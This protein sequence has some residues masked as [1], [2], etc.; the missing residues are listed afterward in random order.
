[1][2]EATHEVTICAQ[3]D[4]IWE[5]VKEMNNWAPLVTGYQRHEII[6]ERHSLWVL[7]GDVGALSRTVELDIHILEW[8]GPERVHFS[9]KGR[10]EDVSGDGTFELFSLDAGDSSTDDAIS[11]KNLVPK[12]SWWARFIRWLFY[13]VLSSKMKSYERSLWGAE[14]AP[15]SS[16]SV[17][18]LSFRFKMEAGGPMA[19]M[20]NA[21][22]GPALIPATQ[23]LTENIASLFSKPES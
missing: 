15:E 16:S 10:N 3:I 21:M 6:D 22:L 2:P 23:S 19:P 11:S 14:G 13:A 8:S 17:T 7:K 18:R 12:Q 9:L 4:D 1:M 20:V 5:V